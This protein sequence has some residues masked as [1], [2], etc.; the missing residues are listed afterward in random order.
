MQAEE[1]AHSRMIEERLKMDP[2]NQL[3]ERCHSIEQDVA[4]LKGRMDLIIK[5]LQGDV[6]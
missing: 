1:L 6:Q 4:A 3:V 5:L 2:I